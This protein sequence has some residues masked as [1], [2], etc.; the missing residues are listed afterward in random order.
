MGVSTDASIILKLRRLLTQAQPVNFYNDHSSLL[1][2]AKITVESQTSRYKDVLYQRPGSLRVLCSILAIP[3]LLCTKRNY[4]V[5]GIC[6][7]RSPSLEVMTLRD[8]I[9]AVAFT[10]K[11]FSTSS[12]SPSYFSRFSRSFF[13]M[14]MSLGFAT[15]T[16]TGFSC[17]LLITTMSSCLAITRP[18]GCQLCHSPLPLEASTT[19][20][21]GLTDNP[22]NFSSHLVTVHC[23]HLTPRY[24]VLDCLGGLFAQPAPG[25]LS[26]VVDPGLHCSC[27]GHVLVLP[28]SVPSCCLL[29]Q[30]FLINDRTSLYQPLLQTVCDTCR[31]EDKPSMMVAP[32]LPPALLVS[33]A[34]GIHLAVHYWGPSS[35]CIPGSLS[36]HPTRR[37]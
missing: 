9:T 8:S 23:L 37:L 20:A 22:V 21:L 33:A 10:S 7:S 1:G 27:A 5:P 28:W 24:Y 3:V 19:L 2:A 34:R 36:F 6:W 26:C 11:I 15:S 13:L 14:L 25:V 16:A 29:N 18:P 30:P 17:S 4:A 12:F 31:A 32:L 35:R